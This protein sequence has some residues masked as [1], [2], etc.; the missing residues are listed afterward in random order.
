MKSQRHNAIKDLLVKTTSANGGG[1]ISNQDELRLRL[2]ARGIHVTQATL[3]RDIRELKLV[4]GSEGYALSANGASDD[5]GP[6][7]AC[8]P[9]SASP[10]PGACLEDGSWASAPVAMAQTVASAT[11]PRYAKRT[12]RLPNAGAFQCH[13]TNN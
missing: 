13:R 10:E 2:A 9:E 11:S 6:A 3:S 8:R 1:A 5:D 12:T 4:K 7:T